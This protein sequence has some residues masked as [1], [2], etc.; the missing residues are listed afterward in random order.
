MEKSDLVVKSNGL[1]KASYTLGLV[2]QRLILMAIVSARN[3][4][5][6]IDANTLL[7]V[8]ATDYAQLFNVTRQTA[9]EVLTG[10]IETLFNRQATVQV[11][12]TQRKRMCPLTVRWVTGMYHEKNT[13]VITLRF[14]HEVIPEIT[15]LEGNFTS[16]QLRE[17]AGISSNYALRLYELLAQWKEVGQTPIFELDE[18]RAQIGLLDGQYIQMCHF[19]TKVLDFSVKQINEHSD[20]LVGYQQIKSGRAITGFTFTVK[21]KT[22]KKKTLAKPKT[23]TTEAQ[24]NWI[25]SDI[26]ERFNSLTKEKQQ[27]IVADTE[28][29]LKGA[30]QARFRAAKSS[31]IDQLI[32]EFAIE[33]NEGIM[34][35]AALM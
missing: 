28:T 2:E 4:Q 11:Y 33:I 17:V 29:R 3:T 22:I 18:F 20:L 23:S 14:S 5:Q 35:A 1:V 12:D 8:S 25:N 9:F 34:R 31:S 27:V 6:G 7:Q 30:N 26:L 19:K 16:Y 15:R 13:G 21:P 32:A 10:A 24:L